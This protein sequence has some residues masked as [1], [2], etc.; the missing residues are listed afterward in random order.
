[1]CTGSTG[2]IIVGARVKPPLV[3][4]GTD[5]CPSTP[6]KK[7]LLGLGP[8]EWRQ[9]NYRLAQMHLQE[10]A[11]ILAEIEH[12]TGLGDALHLAGHVRFEA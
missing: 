6:R 4:S 1:M 3:D 10:S 12:F 5:P 11:E 8:I 2:F 7:G 9:G